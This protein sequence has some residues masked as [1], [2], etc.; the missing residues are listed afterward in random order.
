MQESFIH[1]VS[2][3]E[4][5]E[6]AL[7]CGASSF[8]FSAA[9][10][11][12]EWR[13][14][15]R[16]TGARIFVAVSSA[17][18]AALDAELDRLAPDLPEGV[19]LADCRGRADL[20]RLSVKL[21]VREARANHTDGAVRILAMVGQSAAGALAL[22]DLAGGARRLAGLVYDPCALARSIDVQP[23]TSTVRMAWSQVVVAAAAAGVPAWFVPTAQ[24]DSEILLRRYAQIRRAGYA[25]MILKTPA[26]FVVLRQ[27]QEMIDKWPRSGP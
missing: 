14:H 7:A 21:A 18:S 10:V 9:N 24:E 11:R 22:P 16:G 20:Q 1:E 4:T 3:P 15:A 6:S 19:V 23:A 26:Q 13:R 5:F 27:A 17:D 25:G 8:C 2:S 12:D